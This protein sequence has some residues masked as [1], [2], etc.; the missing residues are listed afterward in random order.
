MFIEGG[1]SGYQSPVEINEDLS[2]LQ[3]NIDFIVESAKLF[4]EEA[5]ELQ[6]A[7]QDFKSNLEP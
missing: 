6:V 3:K 7:I 5:K 4:D 2:N 1:G